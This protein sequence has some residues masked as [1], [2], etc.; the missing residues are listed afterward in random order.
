MDTDG[1]LTCT[2]LNSKKGGCSQASDNCYYDGSNCSD[3]GDLLN[4]NTLTCTG[5]GL[6]ESACK[7]LS[8]CSF[9]NGLC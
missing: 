4:G 8:Y 6:S 3:P 2:Q 9:I 1:T 5:I 7:F